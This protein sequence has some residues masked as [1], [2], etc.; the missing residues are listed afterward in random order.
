M[1]HFIGT[2]CVVD[3]KTNVRPDD[4]IK[5]FFLL[6]FDFS[7]VNKKTGEVKD[8]TLTISASGVPKDSH[9]SR[10]AAIQPLDIVYLSGALNAS[11]DGEIFLTIKDLGVTDE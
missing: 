11:D 9:R 6:E 4:S 7:H 10:W 2:A 8:K 3:I 5:Y 1:N